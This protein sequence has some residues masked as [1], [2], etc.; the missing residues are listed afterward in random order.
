MGWGWVSC[1]WLPAI[2]ISITI[3]PF[4]IPNSI[5]YLIPIPLLAI[6]AIDYLFSQINMH[7]KLASS[8]FCAE[9]SFEALNCFVVQFSYSFPIDFP[10]VGGGY[11]AAISETRQTKKKQWLKVKSVWIHDDAAR[12][13]YR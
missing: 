11:R 3:P 13:S 8:S 4:P 6:P 2:A 1:F 12:L 5:Q 9:N 10:F 7:S